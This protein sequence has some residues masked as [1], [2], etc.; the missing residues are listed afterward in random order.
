MLINWIRCG[1]WIKAPI[2]IN[3]ESKDARQIVLQD[4]K[5][6]V[7]YPMYKEL[8]KY[9]VTY[10]SDDTKRTNVSILLIFNMR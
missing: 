2:I 9:I 8:K 3:N 6:E 7:R 1:Y 5:L 10:T 4:N